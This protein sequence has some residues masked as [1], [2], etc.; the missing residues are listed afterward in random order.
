MNLFHTLQMHK[1]S[2]WLCIDTCTQLLRDPYRKL[3]TRVSSMLMAQAGSTCMGGRHD[4]KYNNGQMEYAGQEQFGL[5]VR[6]EIA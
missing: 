4:R 2:V 5:A 6:D 1:K 3:R